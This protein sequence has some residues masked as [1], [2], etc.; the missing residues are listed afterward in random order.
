MIRRI[1]VLSQKSRPEKSDRPAILF[2]LDGTLLDTIY[3]HVTSRSTAM[4]SAGIVVS[5]WKIHRRI[6]RSG[7]SLVRQ[8]L[9]EVETLAKS[10]MYQH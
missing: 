1:N 6:R 2:D 9:R 5:Q 8:L 4:A 3:N 10:P 7:K